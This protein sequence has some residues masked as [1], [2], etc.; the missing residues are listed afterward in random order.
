MD[1]RRFDQLVR[2]LAQPGSRRTLIKGLLGIGGIAAVGSIAFE[3]EVRAA[4]RPTPTPKPV[5]CPGQQV[6]CDTGCCCPGDATPCGAECCPNSQATC[7]D[8]ACCYGA[9]Y[10]DGLCCE[11]GNPVCSVDGCCSGVCVDNGQHCC[12]PAAVCGD[13]CCHDTERCCTAGLGAP[14][15]RPAGACCVD[16]DCIGGI[17]D[18]G[19]CIPY[20][21]TPQPTAT[22]TPTNTPVPPTS[23]PTDTPT[24]T[25]VPP[26]NTPTDTPTLTPSNTPTDT[27]S[28]TPSNTPMPPQVDVAV[29]PGCF[30]QAIVSNFPPNYSIPEVRFLAKRADGTEF[31]L[32]T[33]AHQFTTDSQGNVLATGTA[34]I[35]NSAV[36]VRA[37]ASIGA[38]VYTSA[39]IQKTCSITPTPSNTPTLT[40]T[41]TVGPPQLTIVFTPGDGGQCQMAVELTNF[42]PSTRYNADLLLAPP[43][44]HSNPIPY[45]TRS[46]TTDASGFVR[47]PFLYTSGPNFLDVQVAVGAVSTD[48]TAVSC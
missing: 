19:T 32:G 31:S 7:C 23:T 35:V 22:D 10:G 42:R 18:R 11:G 5:T 48:W 21:S 45:E 3:D 25:A 26:S 8:G 28:P 4:R 6:P 39:F 2:S 36:Q 33:Y 47:I 16:A 9:C 43:D 37:T 24:N 1:D 14:V 40:P 41:A 15:C 12:R 38:T 17:C 29:T 30:P 13:A 20:T 34:P 27:P 46:G 44:D